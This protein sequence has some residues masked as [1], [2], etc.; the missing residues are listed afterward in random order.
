MTITINQRGDKHYV[1][2]DLKSEKQEHD[3]LVVDVGSRWAWRGNEAKVFD[4]DNKEVAYIYFKRKII[5]KSKLKINLCRE[6][7]EFNLRVKN[8]IVK[9]L[10]LEFNY[11][12]FTYI[13]QE[14]KG[15]FRSLF[16]NDTQV[17]AFEKNAISYFDR[18]VFR[19]YA[20]DSENIV[21]LICLA[22]YDDI[23]IYSDG[24]VVSANTG[25]L[26]GTKPPLDGK[27]RPSKV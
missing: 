12:N 8:W 18:D 24:A 11:H 26:F 20:N 21:F 1:Y 25:N 15:H 7:I 16:K 23:G 17:A 22:I 9:D 4:R 5:G 14:H 10:L 13:L 2:K 6:N 19:I 3:Y 27:W